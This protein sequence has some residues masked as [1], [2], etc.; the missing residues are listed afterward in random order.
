LYKKVNLTTR[1]FGEI[2]V[3]DEDIIKFTCGMYGFNQYR[4]YVILKDAPEDD[5]MFLQSIENTDLSFVL[6]DPFSI[7]NSYEPS[8][9]EEDLDELNVE[10]ESE[11]KYLAIAII[12]EDIKDSVV[13]LKS[14][15]AI[16]P[17]TK[18]AKQ[19]ILQNTY[20]LRYNI[21]VT[22]EELKC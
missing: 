3:S 12:K 11:L 7:I 20:P 18:E 21:I 10:N 17:K 8:L 22:E 13:N 4:K 14:P 16:N 19:V 9:S 15:I 6:I 1:D 2:T 5:I